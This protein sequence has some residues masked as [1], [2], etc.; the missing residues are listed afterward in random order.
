MSGPLKYEYVTITAPDRT[1]AKELKKFTDLLNEYG[2][3]GF[4]IVSTTGS[5]IILQKGTL[6]QQPNRRNAAVSAGLA[7]A[8]QPSMSPEAFD[9][10]LDAGQQAEKVLRANLRPD[11][12]K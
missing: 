11:T 12:K 5:T 1:D 6:L 10:A 8:G 9:S 2:K 3:S 4:H 7:N